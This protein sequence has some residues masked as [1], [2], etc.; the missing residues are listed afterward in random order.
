M[1]TVDQMLA[2]FKSSGGVARGNRYR[3]TFDGDDGNKLNIL[4]DS[5]SM[6]GRQI[7]T[8]EYMTSMKAYKRPYNFINE[9]VS[10]SFILTNDW[11][12]WNYLKD[13][14]SSIINNIDE[15][16]GAYTVNLRSQYA[17]QVIID[18]LNEQNQ[19]T[20]SIKLFNAFPITLNS[21]ELANSNESSILRC[22]TVLAYDNWSENFT[23]TVTIQ[24]LTPV[25]GFG[26][27]TIV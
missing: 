7:A 3:V 6:P 24:P 22:S 13:W 21:T 12:T 20:K 25:T 19:I 23:G 15:D 8:T 2:Q 14:Q 16:T 27:T 17:K 5:V 1:S 10:V 26:I 18:H 9:D 11:Y 4:C